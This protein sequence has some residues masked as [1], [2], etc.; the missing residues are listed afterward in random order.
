MIGCFLSGE[1]FSKALNVLF[2]PLAYLPA[3]ADP[4]RWEAIDRPLSWLER[5]QAHDRTE[6]CPGRNKWPCAVFG[7]V[8]GTR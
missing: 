8:V 2:C 4:R 1:W 3:P 6:A 7:Q 5:Y